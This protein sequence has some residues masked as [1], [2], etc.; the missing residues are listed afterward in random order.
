M[1]D[2]KITAIC[3][4]LRRPV[5]LANAVACFE[6]QDYPAHLR[7]LVIVDDDP[8]PSSGWQ[9]QHGDGWQI[10]RASQRFLTLGAKHNAVVNWAAEGDAI[11]VWDDDDVYAAGH[12]TAI[13]KALEQAEWCA[14]SR[15]WSNYGRNDTFPARIEDATGRFHGAW[16]CTLHAWSVVGGWPETQSLAFD[17]G[18]GVRLRTKWGLPADPC[19]HASPTYCYR[20]NGGNVSAM[21]D[22]EWLARTLQA[23][24][25]TGP[26]GT[27]QP[28]LDAETRTLL[29]LMGDTL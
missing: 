3:C 19:Q 28:Q 18:F 20:W 13:A 23:R 21:G 24:R 16:G 29:R 10:I 7:R 11:A 12:L 26:L 27:L 8:N 4:T 22:G 6:R 25:P 17:Q 5:E 9:S 14:P 15:V 1:S 2:L